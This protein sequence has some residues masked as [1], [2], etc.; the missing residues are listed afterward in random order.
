VP[1]EPRDLPI[2]VHHIFEC[3]NNRMERL[4]CAHTKR[5]FEW[6]RVSIF[7][8]IMGRSPGVAPKVNTGETAII[9]RTFLNIMPNEKLR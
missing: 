6:F 2:L 8:S 5:G 4:P 9:T 3:T 1:C 7:P